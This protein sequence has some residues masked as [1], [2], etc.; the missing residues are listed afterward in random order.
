M[1]YTKYGGIL[2]SGF[3]LTLR[4]TTPVF[5]LLNIPT[6]IFPFLPLTTKSRKQQ[7]S[8]LETDLAAIVLVSF[9]PYLCDCHGGVRGDRSGGGVT[10]C[11]EGRARPGGQRGCCQAR[12][13]IQSRVWQSYSHPVYGSS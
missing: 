4:S 5:L 3:L 8:A 7:N 10:C 9:L 11:L 6:N 12:D 1:G 2:G 13:D